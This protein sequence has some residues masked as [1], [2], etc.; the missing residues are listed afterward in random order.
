[1]P[2]ISE[3]NGEQEPGFK[4]TS[5]AKTIKFAAKV[6]FS[7]RVTRTILKLAPFWKNFYSSSS[8]EGWET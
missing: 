4:D 6:I 5:F 3:G 2:F 7:N 1:M 8:L